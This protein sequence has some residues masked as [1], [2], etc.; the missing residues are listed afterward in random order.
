[1]TVLTELRFVY[2]VEG[3]GKAF[4]TSSLNRA[5]FY[6]GQLAGDG[7]TATLKVQTLDVANQKIVAVGDIAQ[8]IAGSLEET[9]LTTFT[10][11]S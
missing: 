2:R 7:N 9:T 5:Y 6:L 8:S 4:E 3:A 1:M 11:L 10:K